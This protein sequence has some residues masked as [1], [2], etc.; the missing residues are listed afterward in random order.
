MTPSRITPALKLKGNGGLCV[1]G[2]IA[3]KKGRTGNNK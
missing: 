1:T 3:F 2:Q